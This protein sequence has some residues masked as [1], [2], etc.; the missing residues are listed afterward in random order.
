MG[1]GSMW[2]KN[3]HCASTLG[4]QLWE[5]E[6]TSRAC[7]LGFLLWHAIPILY[8]VEK[9]F[10]RRARLFLQSWLCSPAPYHFRNTFL[11]KPPLASNLEGQADAAGLAS[12]PLPGMCLGS[13][14]NSKSV[15]KK[16]LSFTFFHCL[17]EKFGFGPFHLSLPIMPPMPPASFLDSPGAL[18]C[19][20][21]K[22][23][24]KMTF[25]SSLICIVYF[26]FIHLPGSGDFQN[27]FC[28]RVLGG[29]TLES[30]AVLESEA[31]PLSKKITKPT[32]EVCRVCQSS[33]FKTDTN[34][35]P[36]TIKKNAPCAPD[37]ATGNAKTM[38]SQL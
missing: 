18:S 15:P 33:Q 26:S 23:G 5:A 24:V 11:A 29:T 4:C 3:R 10:L 30:H 13:A 35:C 8:A 17:S 31:L 6:V 37:F 32:T 28:S 12:L 2:P 16:S 7:K 34:W 36:C 20:L 9:P 14:R 22:S 38:K 27:L 21:C 1:S 25:F 19:E